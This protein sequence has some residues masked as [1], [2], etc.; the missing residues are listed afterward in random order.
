MEDQVT[1]S[2][3]CWCKHEQ[4]QSVLRDMQR[5]R[6]FKHCPDQSPARTCTLWDEAQRSRGAPSRPKEYAPCGFA[7]HDAGVPVNPEAAS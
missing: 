3:T 6:V 7:L 2:E 4:Q 1:T 5:A